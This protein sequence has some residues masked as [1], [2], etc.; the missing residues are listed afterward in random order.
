MTPSSILSWKHF[1]NLCFLHILLLLLLLFLPTFSPPPGKNSSHL[2]DTSFANL[3]SQSVACLFQSLD[4]VFHEQEVL[5]LMKLSLS[6]LSFM[7]CSFG[8]VSKKSSPN[9]RSSRFS[10]L[11]SKS[12]IVLCFTF[13]S[14]THFEL[15]FVK[16][17]R[18][19]YSF[20]F[21][22]LHVVVQLS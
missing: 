19:V 16:V 3:C 21:F 1:S 11:S 17:V 22:F 18:S 12:F 4:R 7:N 8:V 14:A 13:W 15:I 10:I 6:I 2:S 20:C 9:P 5:V